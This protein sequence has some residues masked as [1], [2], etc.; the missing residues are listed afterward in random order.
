MDTDRQTDTAGQG[1][2]GDLEQHQQQL[3]PVNTDR[4]TD[5]TGQGLN[6][7]LEKHQQQLLPVDT[8][9]QTDRHRQ[10]PTAAPTAAAPCGHR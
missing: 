10:T 3:L 6:G 5:T 8:D 4:Q 7:D 2:N 1:L 9:R